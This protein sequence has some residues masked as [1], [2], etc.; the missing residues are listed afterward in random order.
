MGEFQDL[1]AVPAERKEI[2]LR[3]NIQN[4]EDRLPDADHLLFGF[5]R[6]GE[7]GLAAL[8]PS[9]RVPAGNGSARRSSLP[10]C[11][12]GNCSTRTKWAGTITSGNSDASF[13]RICEGSTLSSPAQ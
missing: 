13:A 5:V 4:T 10:L 7:C 11:V 12:N 8:F 2:I 1:E 9:L 6:R 3:T